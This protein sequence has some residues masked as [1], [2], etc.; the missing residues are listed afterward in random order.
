MRSRNFEPRMS[1]DETTGC[2]NAKFCMITPEVILSGFTEGFFKFWP[3]TRDMGPPP[4]GQGRAKIDKK[5]FSKIR[6]FSMD[7]DRFVSVVS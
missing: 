2:R 1:P 5:F 3:R 6:I 7:F 4:G